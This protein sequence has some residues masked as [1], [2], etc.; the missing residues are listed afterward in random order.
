MHEQRIRDI[1]RDR[2]D[3]ALRS[4]RLVVD[5]YRIRRKVA[6]TLPIRAI[7]SPEYPARGFENYPWATWLLWALEDRIASLGW[8]ADWFHET[9]Y[10]TAVARDLRALAGFP[11]FDQYGF[12][13]LALGHCMRTLVSAH[14]AWTWLPRDVRSAIRAACALAVN[15]HGGWVTDRGK[16][17]RRAKQTPPEFI[18]NIPV[19]GTLGCAMA[20][21]L[22]G[23]SAR[24]RIDAAAAALLHAVLDER[25]AG[26][27]EG[28][29][30]DGYVLD[31]AADWLTGLDENSRS[32]PLSRIEIDAILDQSESLAVPG[33][34]MGVA[35]I[36]DVEPIEMPFHASAHAKLAAL[37]DRPRSVSYLDRCDPER[38]RGD[39]LAN[40]AR[41]PAVRSNDAT[42]DGARATRYALVVRSGSAHRDLAAVMAC[43]ECELGHLH[44]DNGT[45]TIGARGRWF[46]DDPGYQQYLPT[47]EK[48]FTT[49]STAHNAPLINGTPQTRKVVGHSECVTGPDGVNRI[50][51]DITQCYDVAGV[52]R[53]TRTAWLMGRDAVVVCDLLV[54]DQLTNLTYHW[55]GHADA[56]WNVSD[57]VAELVIDDVGLSIICSRAHLTERMVNRLPGSRGQLTISVDIP[58]VSETVVWWVFSLATHP[59]L[60]EI[61]DDRRTLL[62]SGRPLR[63]Q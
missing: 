2:A 62:W 6:Y 33:D 45:V 50:A 14:R 46:V 22:A 43:S 5:Y 55:H 61:S 60:P 51:V 31:F 42:D 58:A 17:L 54:G 25:S 16:A 48:G 44:R 28:V 12:P 18:A 20:A 23:H 30:Y 34:A 29:S 41:L 32:D 8:A 47:N 40:M 59:T 3:R 27:T 57:G 36:G 63:V 37:R 35:P 26:R 10:T 24:D 21:R 39:A 49:G 1:V 19:I 15:E 4:E 11:R 38:L 7:P 53:V 56:A 52:D 9:P 13:D